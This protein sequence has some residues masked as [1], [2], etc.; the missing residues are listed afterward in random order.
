M[1]RTIVAIADCRLRGDSSFE[2]FM[3]LDATSEQLQVVERAVE[4]QP[5]VEA[6]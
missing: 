5:S 4:Q 6:V 2:V 3:D 1:A